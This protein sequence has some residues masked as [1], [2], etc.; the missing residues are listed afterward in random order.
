MATKR[1]MVVT[2]AAGIAM[3]LLPWPA[4][5]GSRCFGRVPTITD[6]AEGHVIH[7]TRDD[8][9]IAA[10]GGKDRIFARGGDDVICAGGNK[11][12]VRG[13]P[14]ADLIAG[15][16]GSDVPFSTSENNDFLGGLLGNRGDDTILGGDGIDRLQGGKGDDILKGGLDSDNK[17][18]AAGIASDREGG[19]RPA[20]GRYHAFWAGMIRGGG[21]NDR[22]AGEQAWDLLDSRDG[23]EFNDLL[24]GGV[25][26]RDR[27]RSDPDRERRC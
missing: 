8:D 11:D 2:L 5:A 22:L 6:G 3:S 27:C 21:G 10:R 25:G 20:G 26:R 1:L 13:G 24:N 23:V 15:G 12:R 17:V 14:G 18:G 9:V 4:R 7:G 19:P 16:F